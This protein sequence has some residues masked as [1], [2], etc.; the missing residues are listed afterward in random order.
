M[1]GFPFSIRSI[2]WR[3]LEGVL[4][5]IKRRKGVWALLISALFLLSCM[6][7]GSALAEEASVL[8]PMMAAWLEKIE[9]GEPA[10]VTLSASLHALVP[11]GDE[12]LSMMNRLLSEC[13]INVDWQKT[14]EAE[15]IRTQL[16]IGNES[17][18]DIVEQ[19]GE[20][21]LAQTSLLP[22]LTLSSKDGSPVSQLLGEETEI[23]FWAVEIPDIHGIAQKLPDVLSSLNEYKAEK[24]GSFKLFSVTTARKALVYT[25]PEK[26]VERLKDVLLR[27]AAAMRWPEAS[28]LFSTVNTKGDAEITLYQTS[29]AVNVGLGLKA[30]MGFDNV[31]VRK[32]NFLWAFR[33]DVKKSVQSMSLK[34]P[35]DDGADYLTVIGDF[36]QEGKKAKNTLSFDLD[37]KSRMGKEI[38]QEQWKGKLDCL[39]AEDNQ[40]LEGEVKQTV[41]G[42]DEDVHTLL[43]RP[44]LLAYRSG[45]EVSLKGNARLTLSEGKSVKADVTVSLAADHNTDLVFSSDN[46]VISL[47]DMSTEEQTALAKKAQETAV[48]AIWQA[49]MALPEDALALIKRNITQDDWE[50]IYRVVFQVGQ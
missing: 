39:L 32:V 9:S 45:E 10:N 30:S 15:T 21:M 46:E 23:P 29:D 22:G 3:L 24:E 26:D 41:S 13:K 37:I 40:R 50:E 43:I 14:G 1:Q 6:M 48:A 18:V 19:G 27:F 12:T 42:V 47:S 20:Q 33:S 31:T 44:S 4:Q 8:S 28:A 5:M 36:I 2:P 25:I 11:F 38:S 16:L 49:V 34:A 35:A 17:A 7:I